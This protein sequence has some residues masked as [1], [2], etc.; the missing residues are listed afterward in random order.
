MSPWTDVS[1]HT[2]RHR[3]GHKAGLFEDGWWVYH[4]SW[5]W[6]PPGTPHVGPEP[7][8]PFIILDEAKRFV[9]SQGFV[10]AIPF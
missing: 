10:M 4:A 1:P 5:R 8:G 2:S 3:D 7:A 6:T 9:E